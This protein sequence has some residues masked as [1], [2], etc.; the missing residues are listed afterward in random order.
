MLNG[1]LFRDWSAVIGDTRFEHV[2]EVGLFL[3]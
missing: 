2:F 1:L 3:D